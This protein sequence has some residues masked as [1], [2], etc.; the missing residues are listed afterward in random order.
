MVKLIGPLPF[1]QWPANLRAMTFTFTKDGKSYARTM[2]KN[3]QQPA[4]FL[5]QFHPK[6]LEASAAWNGLKS[7]K[8][9]RWTAC[10]LARA[11]SG[12]RL[13]AAEYIKQRIPSPEWIDVTT[14]APD[15]TT[16]T[17]QVW[18]QKQPISPCSRRAT[19]PA[20]SPWDYTP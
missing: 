5:Q 2:A 18:H 9:A 20:A 10:A 3:A 17:V 14:T 13:Y 1:D 19:D 16:T 8:R 12:F 11:S 6:F 4:T 15:G 7:W